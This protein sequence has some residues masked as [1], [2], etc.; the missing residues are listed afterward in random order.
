MA[1][2]QPES[3]AVRRLQ[4]LFAQQGWVAYKTHGSAYQ[5]GFPD[6]YC[7]HKLFRSR[8]V[9][10]KMPWGKLTPA[11]RAVFPQLSNN[12]SPI[13]IIKSLWPVNDDQLLARI[14]FVQTCP[15]NWREFL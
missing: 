2:R 9:E 11:Q 7:T 6:L 3:V 13:W 15:E 4:N 14:R 5:A 1:K 8:L 12:G 10:V